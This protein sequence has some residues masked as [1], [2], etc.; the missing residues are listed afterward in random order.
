[1][2]TANDCHVIQVHTMLV[3]LVLIVS[4]LFVCHLQGSSKYT[5]VCYAKESSGY[6]VEILHVV[7]RR[8][9]CI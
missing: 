7:H 2:T 3:K 9:N 1:M 5:Y 8:V 6:S 4:T